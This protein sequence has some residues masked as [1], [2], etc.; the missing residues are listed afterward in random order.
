[1]RLQCASLH[2]VC[3]PEPPAGA[4]VIPA[5][6]CKM[7]SHAPHGHVC[8][9]SWAGHMWRRSG[10]AHRPPATCGLVGAGP[11]APAFGQRGHLDHKGSAWSFPTEEER[12]RSNFRLRSECV[13]SARIGN[14]IVLGA[15]CAL[16]VAHLL[17]SVKC[18]SLGGF[19]LR[20]IFTG[21]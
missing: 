6:P 17:A 9:T 16:P 12:E 1:M 13:P 3:E 18:K 20:S 19:C 14:S 5:A 11:G 21:A 10:L 15:R 8:L 7:Q 2:C 4:A